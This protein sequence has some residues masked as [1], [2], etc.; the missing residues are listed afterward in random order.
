MLGHGIALWLTITAQVGVASPAQIV[1]PSAADAFDTGIDACEALYAGALRRE[2]RD[3][4]EAG[5]FSERGFYM[6]ASGDEAKVNMLMI[7]NRA[8]V[9]KGSTKDQ[10]GVVY[11]VFSLSPLSCRVG[12]FDA[13]SSEASALKRL[14][15]PSSGWV[16]RP[17]TSPSPAAKM[18]LFDKELVGSRATLNVSWPSGSGVGPNGLSGMTTMILEGG[19]KALSDQ[20]AT[21]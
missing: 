7:G 12:S 15:E 19:L 14:S 2:K 11:I 16:A 17:T 13:P 8:H 18:Q 20:P 4:S 9:Y 5:P 10:A 1:F 3:R 6:S 21:R